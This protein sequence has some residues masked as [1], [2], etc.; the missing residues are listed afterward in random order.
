MSRKCLAKYPRFCLEWSPVASGATYIHRVKG[1]YGTDVTSHKGENAIAFE[2]TGE[3]TGMTCAWRR[4][5]KCED[6]ISSGIAP[7]GCDLHGDL[8]VISELTDSVTH[9]G[10][11]RRLACQLFE[12]L[13]RPASGRHTSLRRMSY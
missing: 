1:S 5:N 6:S 8:L 7:T 11:E 3:G 10:C 9:V 4:S 2:G 12:G 13:R